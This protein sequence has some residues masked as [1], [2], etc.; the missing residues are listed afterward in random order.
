MIKLFKNLTKKD[1][2]LVLSVIVLV[3]FS[4]FLDLKMPEYMS[5]I[6]VLVQTTDDSMN[7]ILKAGLYMMGCAF[8]SLFCT[9]A[10]GYL[11][12]LLSARF[13]KIVRRKLFAK[14]EEFGLAEIKKFHTSSLIT[15]TTNDVTQIEMLLAMGLQLIIKS[16]VMA[17]WAM[18]KIIGKSMELSSVTAIGVVIIVVTNIIIICIVTPRFVK[19]QKL[20]DDINAVI[21][22][23]ITG[24]R[25]VRAFNAEKFHEER[26]DKVN[27]G[28]TDIH[29]KVTKTFALLDPVM[30]F[31]MHFQHL[32]IYI[33]GAILILNS[34]MSD[35]ITIFS[36]MVVFSSY[37]MQVIISFLMLTMIFMI[38]PRAR[39]SANRINE[40]LEEDISIK[41]GEFN[42]KT[43]KT[44]SIEFKNVSFKYPDAEDYVLKNISF[45]VNRGETIAF[46][47]STGSGKSTLINLVPRLY[48]ATDGEVCVDGV[49]VKDYVIKDLNNKIGYI[50]QTPVMFT[51]SIEENVAY[52]DNGKGKISKD[53]VKE[54]IKIAQAKDFVEAM[55]DNYKA[56]IARGGTNIS[57]GQKQRLSIARAIARDPEIYIFD[58]SFS[59]LDYKTD[60]ALRKDL[61]QYTKDAT[62]LIVAQRIGTIMNADKIIV[63]DKGECV[64]IGTHEELLKTCQIY[65]EIAFSQLSE[66]E[67]ENA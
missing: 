1:Y 11:T 2:L 29:L 65:K 34:T 21:R 59:A 40:V 15:R 6:T 60:S 38:L 51:G 25:V 19:I 41:S 57:G 56:H 36:N 66:E 8:G 33:V 49:N 28:I 14:V 53:K 27:N 9:I 22:E 7:E 61:N 5:E 17:I 52:G 30:N 47:G 26:F 55:E 62:V 23:N 42:S 12:A 16:P 3:V 43:E 58:D 31:V 45:K 64:G 13:S 46:I 24:I 44:G 67:L 54:A 48:D 4:V 10:V 50:P 39:V 20:T 32:A 63:L 35:K 18:S 37:G